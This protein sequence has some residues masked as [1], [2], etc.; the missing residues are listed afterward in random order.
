[1]TRHG[2]RGRLAVLLVAAGS[3]PASRAEAQGSDPAAAADLFHEG[4]VAMASQ[5]YGVACA[6]FAESERLDPRV[7][8]LI[9]LAQCEEALGLLATA[10]RYWEQATDL[11]KATGDARV[12]YTTE[13]LGAIDHRVPR[14]T[15]RLGASAP[16]GTI[17]HRDDVELGA[18]SLGTSLPVDPGK[19]SVFAAAAHHAD[20]PVTVVELQ[21]GESKEVVVEAGDALPEPAPEAPVEL[22][23]PL[24]PETAPARAAGPTRIAAIASGAAGVV[25]VG[26]GAY[27]GL[28]AIAHESGAPGVCHGQTCD[29]QGATVRRGAIQSADESTAAFVVGG[30]LLAAGV[31]LWLVAPARAQTALTVGVAPDL[32]V[33]GAGAGVVGSF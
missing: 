14:L 17:A 18:A 25:G 27:F 7:G 33:R 31:V 15:V 19:H 32:V 30:A 29:A 21:A 2:R 23:H 1:V 3:L 6:K 16:P 22:P 13:Q 12:A 8:T 20:G 11:A 10:R 28:Q 24:A 26:L 5:S 4:R 9:N